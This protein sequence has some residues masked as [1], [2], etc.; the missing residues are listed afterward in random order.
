MDIRDVSFAERAQVAIDFSGLSSPELR[1]ALAAV[2]LPLSRTHFYRLIG[3]EVNDPRY[4]TIAALIAATGVPASW[5]FDPAVGA[6]DATPAG[7][8]A[9]L[10]R[11]GFSARLA[12]ADGGRSESYGAHDDPGS[13]E[14]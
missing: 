3:G 14:D 5:F 12:V 4:S 6:S 9:Y 10:D 2:G 1:E 13:T 8:A 7:L 11:V